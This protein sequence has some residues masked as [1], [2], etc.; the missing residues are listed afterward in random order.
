MKSLFRVTPLSRIYRYSS[1]SAAHTYTDAQRRAINQI[2][3]TFLEAKEPSIINKLEQS[4][5]SIDDWKRHTLGFRRLFMAKPEQSL[6][7]TDNYNRFIELLQKPDKF[8]ETKTLLYDAMYKSALNVLK[9]NI[10]ALKTLH[11]SSDLTSPPEWYPLARLLKRKII[12]H[13]GPTNSGKVRLS[14]CIYRRNV[15]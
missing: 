4:Y 8:E 12:Y 11:G 9:D 6:G 2:F 10:K 3:A 13:G 15:Y 1:T 5:I 7:G 14:L